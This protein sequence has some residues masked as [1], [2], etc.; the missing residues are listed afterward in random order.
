VKKREGASKGPQKNRHPKVVAQNGP[1][2]PPT[3]KPNLNMYIIK[4]PILNPKIQP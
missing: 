4:S 3:P 2:L 1:P